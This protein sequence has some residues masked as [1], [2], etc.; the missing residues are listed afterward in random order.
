MWPWCYSCVAL[1]LKKVSA[2]SLGKTKIKMFWAPPVAKIK[3]VEIF[4]FLASPPPSKVYDETYQ[5]INLEMLCKEKVPHPLNLG[6]TPSCIRW[7]RPKVGN[8]RSRHSPLAFTNALARLLSI[9]NFV[10]RQEMANKSRLKLTQSFQMTKWFHRLN[11]DEKHLPK[12]E[13]RPCNWVD[14]EHQPS[15]LGLFRG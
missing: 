10:G 6:Q 1:S 8:L 12:S 3:K 15:K 14:G 2:L 7:S 9:S 13:G 11:A 5:Q 4:K